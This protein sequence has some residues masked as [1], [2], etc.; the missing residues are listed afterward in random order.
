MSAGVTA[1]SRQWQPAL[2]RQ[3]LT[4]PVASGIAIG[5]VDTAIVETAA[6][7]TG[8]EALSRVAWRP[9]QVQ[10]SAGS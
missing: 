7:M 3:A 2:P 6:N 10:F 1:K 8:D 4:T 9:R 5:A